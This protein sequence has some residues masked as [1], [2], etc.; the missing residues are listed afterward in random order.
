MGKVVK[1][2]VAVAVTV[3]GVVTGNPLLV[4]IG[5][6]GLSSALTKKP[7]VSRQPISV[8][9]NGTIEPARGIYGQMRVS[10]WN[11]IPSWTS[12][13]RG[14]MLHQVLVL[15]GWELDSITDV[16]LNQTT[17]SSASIGAV[18]GTSSDG[19]V[20]TG[21]YANNIWIRRY[22]GTNSQTVD[23]ILD[24]AFAVW[25]SNHRLRDFAYLALQYRYSTI[26]EKNGKPEVSCLV[27]GARVYDP[28]LDSTNGG[29]GSH[30]YDTPSTWAY[31]NNP[32]L[33]VAHYLMWDK[34][35]GG[36]GIVPTRIDWPLIAAAANEC[37]ELVSIPGS[38]T[39]KRYTC[40][41]VI[42]L[43]KDAREANLEALLGAMLGHAYFQGGKWRVYAGSWQT[44]S[45]TITELDVTEGMTFD[46]TRDVS[47][48]WNAV[49]GTYIDAAR[50]YT[51][52]EFTP[53]TSTTYQTEDGVSA[54]IF[55][56]VSF[57]A[58]TNEY[59]A[60]RAAIIINR[61][62]R[63]PA[64]VS[65]TGGLSLLKVRPYETG[66][67]SIPELG[68]SSW[69][70]RANR[71]E[72][73][74]ETGK[75]QLLLQEESSAVWSDPL[76][77][78]YAT[79]TVNSSPS[80]GEMLP[81]AATGLSVSSFFASLRFTVTPPAFVSPGTMTELWEHTALT[82]FASATLVGEYGGNVITIDRRDVTNRFYWVTYKTP[83]GRRSTEYPSG[84]G[85]SAAAT[86]ITA[87]DVSANGLTVTYSAEDT[88]TN[89]IVT[90]G[91]TPVR[92]ERL[93]T[94]DFTPDLDGD[95]TVTI[96]YEA[97]SDNA[98]VPLVEAILRESGVNVAT[99]TD[100]NPPLARG[101]A[102]SQLEF[103]VTGGLTYTAALNVKQ[104]S[105]PV[106]SVFYR[107]QTIV[108]YRR[109]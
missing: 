84:A 39:Q 73:D 81:E 60:Q 104:S 76:S 43:D 70:C 51:P 80:V 74:S 55:K 65:I 78:D 95:V 102:T 53:V 22:R 1:A 88:A 20:S 21:D 71:F 6:N 49:K 96:T 62:S 41:I 15:A 94:L 107:I 79:Q 61:L 36:Y 92:T 89:T 29:S 48:H 14:E 35:Y 44:P 4:S 3:V 30:R 69:S 10:G 56:E 7:K 68:L 38:T 25:G 9:Y 19:L 26:Y 27:T 106:T 100:N 63:Y 86:R 57:A 2:L 18:S 28:R 40:N 105:Q 46:P 85:V 91:G 37:D 54:P 34:R 59:E 52:Q 32:A 90:N 13:T 5:L 67:I 93:C 98:T 50:S 45:F 72:Y 77:T 99:G 75:V 108:E 83:Q 109:R 47:D 24:T 101:M 87:T 8:E 12:G 64:Q 103:S 42:E 23:Y 97:E 11:A 33:C 82:P 31:S 16:Y 17:V 66:T 58:C